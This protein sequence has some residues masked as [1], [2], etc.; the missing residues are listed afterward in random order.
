[1]VQVRAVTHTTSRPNSSACVGE[2]VHGGKV[3]RLNRELVYN[4]RLLKKTLSA[5]LESFPADL[6]SKHPD[7][8][9]C[10]SSLVVRQVGLRTPDHQTCSLVP[11]QKLISSFR[12]KCF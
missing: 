6:S 10:D 2:S 1:M 3:G 8:S 4:I 11:K 7:V 12:W 9:S 5:S